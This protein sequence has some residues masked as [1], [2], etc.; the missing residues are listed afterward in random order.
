[1]MSEPIEIPDETFAKSIDE[2]AIQS[3]ES[4]ENDV[5]LDSPSP[6]V[7]QV[8]EV[9][10]PKARKLGFDVDEL[11]KAE[12]ANFAGRPDLARAVVTLTLGEALGI[13]IGFTAFTR[14]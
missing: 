13:P 3:A 9:L 8:F 4:R 14:S 10:A 1:M 12:K 7:E 5:S 11:V 6:S 2:F